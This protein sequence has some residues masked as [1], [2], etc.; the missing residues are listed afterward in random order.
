MTGKEYEEMVTIKLEC[1]NGKDY[2]ILDKVTGKRIGFALKHANKKTGYDLYPE[3]DV[4]EHFP[5]TA[6]S[7]YTAWATFINQYFLFRFILFLTR[8]ILSVIKKFQNELILIF[9]KRQKP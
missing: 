4:P 9:E 8:K 6:S 7:I 1:I 5:K 3:F 2:N